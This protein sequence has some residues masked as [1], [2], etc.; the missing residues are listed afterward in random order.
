MQ[1]ANKNYL[2]NEIEIANVA[3]NNDGQLETRGPYQF[4]SG[5]IYEG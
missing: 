1:S 2:S 4:R 5:A 3:S